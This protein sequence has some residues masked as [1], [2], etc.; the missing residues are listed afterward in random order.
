MLNK[1]LFILFLFLTISATTFSQ[2]FSIDS[3]EQVIRTTKNDSIK[4]RAMSKLGWHYSDRDFEKSLQKA[5]EMLELATKVNR[6][7]DIANAY[8]L[9]G[10]TY[11]AQSADMEK[12]IPYFEK[13]I[14]HY[15]QVG[16]DKKKANILSNIGLS[17]RRV[18]DYAKAFSYNLQAV[19]IGEMLRD[20]STLIYTINNMAI[21]Y[22]KMDENEKAKQYYIKSLAYAEAI[23]YKR[24]IKMV[25]NNLGNVY[26]SLN[27]SDSA[28]IYFNRTLSISKKMNYDYGTTLG[29]ANIGKVYIQQ[30][31]YE[32][33]NQALK[34]AHK[35]AIQLDNNLNVQALVIGYLGSAAFHQGNYT[36]AIEYTK[37]AIEKLGN[38]EIATQST[39]YK[40]LANSYEKT[41]QLPFAL[42]N[43]KKFQSLQDSIYNQERQTQISKLEVKYETAKKEEQLK[44][45]KL[46]LSQKTKQRNIFIFVAIAFLALGWYFWQLSHRLK[47][48]KLTIESQ[49]QELQQ[50]YDDK[51]RFFANIAHELRTPLT[52]IVG[53]VAHVI[54]TAQLSATTQQ[55]LN[56]VNR[57]VTYLKQLV[58]QILDLSK[59]EVDELSLQVS[60]FDFSDML[61]TLIDDF[62][63]FAQY[64][65]IGFQTPNN[66]ETSIQLTTD[67]EKLFIILKNLLS[68][69]FKY[70]HSDGQVM[71]NYIEIGDSLQI[72]IQDTGKGILEKDLD[73]IFK[74][75][76]QSSNPDAPIEGGTGIG[77]AIC[78]TYIEQLGGS[79]QVN[80]E[81]GKGSM[82]II[83]FPKQLAN[84]PISETANLSFIQKNQ[85][86]TTAPT[87][88]T[89]SENA[90]SILIVED[91][92]DISQHLQTILQEDYQITFASNGAEGLVALE[93][94]TPDLILT[95][96]MMPVMNGFEF[97]E[98]TK[99][100]DKWR[101]IPIITL[102]ARSEMTDK[103]SALRIGVDDY[104][105]KPFLED[106]LKVRI[107]NLLKN[108][109]NRQVFLKEIQEKIELTSLQEPSTTQEIIEPTMTMEDAE[110][111][112]SLEEIVNEQINNLNFNVNQLCFEM[113]VS[114]SQL[115]QKLK[116]LT[117]STPKQY[118]DQIRYAKA[119]KLLETQVYGS[120]KRVAYEV[121]FK[122][123]KNF[124]RNFKKRFGAYPSTYLN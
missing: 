72:S 123:E 17:Y 3:V 64:Q 112:K 13:A 7:V 98:K 86:N 45:Q 117:G 28:L 8:N 66:I 6:H 58:N 21:L 93:K 4:L 121:G 85:Y 108:S 81:L 55:S 97:I 74:P 120:I 63:P 53:P 25:C 82:F 51:N 22:T 114:S 101:S 30:K 80:S 41:G 35:Y 115:Y 18:G 49:T 34:E 91:N 124:S 73:H 102:T 16:A 70:T 99:A 40:R 54:K 84:Y 29:F 119:R 110:W 65:K 78:K 107:E 43:H 75:Y 60:V 12:V 92:L 1:K 76:F 96:L 27:K 118:I 105:V 5:E 10:Y 42:E 116:K 67:G 88:V 83:Q 26:H 89:A 31:K 90:P 36:K 32:L 33:A 109:E 56:V 77:L 9:M 103:L 15:D 46:E 122:D 94:N 104:L 44:I 71:L 69:A 47:A 37:K 100:Q 39:L 68:N 52:L 95:D 24:M 113:A 62:Q 19:K 23:N 59:K 14:Y 48:N 2:S 106:E 87:I 61:Q 11:D 57:N 79:I 20:T 38:G 111:L 50:L